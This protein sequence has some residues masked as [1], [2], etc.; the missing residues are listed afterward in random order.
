MGSLPTGLF[1]VLQVSMRTEQTV[2]IS[3]QQDGQ[4]VAE[5]KDL[6]PQTWKF[7]TG[8]LP[9]GLPVSRLETEW[10]LLSI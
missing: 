8:P 10:F 5:L 2:N 3:R 1:L 6:R 9:E 4:L 7:A